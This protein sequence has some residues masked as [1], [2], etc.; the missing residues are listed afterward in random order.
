MTSTLTRDIKPIAVSGE[1]SDVY[2]PPD[3]PLT[4]DPE[5]R[6]ECFHAQLIDQFGDIPQVHTV[7]AYQRKRELQ[8]PVTIDDYTDFLEAQYHLWEN[9]RTLRVLERLQQEKEQ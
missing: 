6:A 8:I 9:K 4:K 5:L 1:D 2:P 3:W 7:A